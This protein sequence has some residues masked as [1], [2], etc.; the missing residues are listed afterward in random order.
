MNAIPW[1]RKPARPGDVVAGVDWERWSVVLCK[2]DAVRRGLVDT[3]LARIAALDAT[4][5]A[6]TQVVVEPWQ[7][8]VH[9]W[10]LL[11][12][13]DWY[14]CK[15]RACL[16]E[17]Y[18][19][20]PVCVALAYGT[21]GIH[22]RLRRALGHFDPTQAGPGTIRGD[23]G[24]DSAAAAM[25]DSRLV[26]NLIHTS[27]DPMAARRDFGTW[28]GAGRRALLTPPDLRRGGTAPG[29]Q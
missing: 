20:K 5:L 23:L 6:R 12:D 14:Y 11:V 17:M 25:A 13:A 26:E 16:D 7:V 8:H 28:F 29:G 4:V 15:V 10:D 3:L 24:T 21:P 18:V 1:D 19:G 22:G 27:D 9:Y 2:P